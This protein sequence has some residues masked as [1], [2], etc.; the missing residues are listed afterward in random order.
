M[1]ERVWGPVMRPRAR[2]RSREA[3]A[4]AVAGATM[5]CLFG[6]GVAF[7]N[8]PLPAQNAPG[9]TAFIEPD[10]TI[11][12]TVQGTWNW[13]F[14]G[15]PHTEG[16]NATLGNPCDH[17][18]G[19]G[20]GVVWNDPNDPGNV[21]TYTNQ[22]QS[23]TVGI[24]STGII[25]ANNDTTVHSNLPPAR[26]G[27]FTQTNVPGFGDGTV[28]GT[29]SGTHVYASQASLPSQVC[30][31]T[32]DLGFGKVPAPAYVRFTN[33]DNSVVWSLKLNRGW[34]TSAAGPNCVPMPTPVLAP[35]PPPTTPPPTSPPVV[36][37]SGPGSGTPTPATPATPASVRST[38][39]GTGPATAAASGGALAFTGFGRTGQLLCLAGLLLVLLGLF[40]YFVDVRRT[41]QWLLGL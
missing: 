8:S 14:S 23:V 41:V 12:V 26:C 18:A 2:R 37:P 33:D 38:S 5:A 15:L 16:L 21:Q 39:P 36:T 7:A 29:W 3:A 31:V 19:V 40:L 4:V 30:V 25:S 11:D 1:R 10:G 6:A 27:T 24:G 9:N 13:P 35:N 20:W 17:R 22:R 34:T 32:F 28:S